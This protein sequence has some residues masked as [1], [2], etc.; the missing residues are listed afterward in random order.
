MRELSEKEHN[1]MLKSMLFASIISADNDEFS[2][3]TKQEIMDRYKKYKNDNAWEYILNPL[4]DEGVP[5]ETITKYAE[6]MRA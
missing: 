4:S 2:E 5:S 3:D 1:E 6:I